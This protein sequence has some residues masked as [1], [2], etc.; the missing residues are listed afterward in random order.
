MGVRADLGH[1]KKTF[2]KKWMKDYFSAEIGGD[3]IIE[4]IYNSY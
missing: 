4:I 3:L 1:K 2:W